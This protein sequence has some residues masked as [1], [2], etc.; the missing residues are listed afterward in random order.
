M[1]VFNLLLSLHIII[2]NKEWRIY[3][4]QEAFIV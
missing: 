3:G 2:V 1:D 4:S